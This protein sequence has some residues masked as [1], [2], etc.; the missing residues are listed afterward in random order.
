MIVF[1][2]RCSTTW[3]YRDR[4]GEWV[5]QQILVSLKRNEREEDE[6]IVGCVVSIMRLPFCFNREA[7]LQYR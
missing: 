6:E 2:F 1:E 4:F 7:N 3:V 5:F